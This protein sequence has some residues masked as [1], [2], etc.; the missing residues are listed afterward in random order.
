YFHNDHLLPHFKA[1]EEC[2]FVLVDEKNEKRKKAE[3]Q[4]RRLG[5]LAQKLVDEPEKLKITL[6]Q[7]EEELDIHIRFEERDFFPYIQEQ[8]DEEG[9][10][11]LRIKLEEIHEE[12]PE[13]W[14]DKFWEKKPKSDMFSKAC[15]YGIRAVIIIESYSKNNKKIGIKEICNGINAPEPFTAKILQNLRKLDI[16]NSTKGPNGGFF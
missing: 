12:V 15:E 8:Q 10:E 5:R 14:E 2:V 7:I 4:H 6:G 13:V 1:E 11:L 9:L 16:I 3:S